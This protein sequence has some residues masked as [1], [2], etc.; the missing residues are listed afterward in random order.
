MSNFGGSNSLSVT[1][2]AGCTWTAVSNTA[3]LSVIGG[4]SGTGNGTV[5]YRGTANSVAPRVGTLTVAGYTFTVNQNG[6]CSYTVSPLS[7]SIPGVGGSG[8]VT[9]TTTTTCP[10]TA[11][12]NVAWITPTSPSGTGA[13][14]VTFTVAPNTTGSTRLGLLTVSGRNVQISQPA[15]TGSLPPST[16]ANLRI[17]GSGQ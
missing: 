12:T 14:A 13:G 7:V 16:P 1:T 6:T 15:S 8:Q 9:V 5:Y 3:W 2:Q 4:A 10:W 17:I 11:T